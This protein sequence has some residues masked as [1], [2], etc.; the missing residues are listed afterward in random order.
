[1]NGSSGNGTP[2]FVAT[3]R[4]L[5][6]IFDVD[7]RTV[8][9]W[10]HDGGPAK[11]T[12]GY[13]VRAWV[14][15]IFDRHGTTDNGDG[16]TTAQA[17]RRLTV[18]KADREQLRRNREACAVIDVSEHE[19]I[20]GDVIKWVVGLFEALPNELM[21]RLGSLI[22]DRRAGARIVKGLCDEIRRDAAAGQHQGG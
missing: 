12:H 22:R 2:L 15:W 10:L 19:R 4:E 21:V 3:Q 17:T 18:A 14:Q 13:D 5:A 1:M 16:E 20:V 6:G 7:V 11:T 9:R 8:R